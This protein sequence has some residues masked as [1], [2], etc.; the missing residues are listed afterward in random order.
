MRKRK[1]RMCIVISKRTHDK[2]NKEKGINDNE[3]KMKK[4]KSPL[5]KEWLAVQMIMNI[6][7]MRTK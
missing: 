1:C 7:K 5:A 2:E 4:E 6:I 3:K